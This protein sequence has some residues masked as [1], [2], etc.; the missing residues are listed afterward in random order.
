LPAGLDDAGW[1]RNRGVVKAPALAGP[2]TATEAAGAPTI[3]V[4]VDMRQAG[5]HGQMQ[6]WPPRPDASPLADTCSEQIS[7]GATAPDVRLEMATNPDSV[8]CRAIAQTD[9]QP[10][11]LIKARRDLILGNRTAYRTS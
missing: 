10:I 4:R 7:G 5:P 1:Q 8:T 3:A 6:S 2:M 11:R 9:N